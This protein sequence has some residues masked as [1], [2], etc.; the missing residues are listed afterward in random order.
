MK[1][2][3]SYY[4]TFPNDFSMDR[5]GINTGTQLWLTLKGVSVEGL[6]HVFY[7]LPILYEWIL[8]RRLFHFS[9][10]LSTFLEGWQMQGQSRTERLLT[11]RAQRLL[12]ALPSSHWSFDEASHFSIALLGFWFLPIL[13][14]TSNGK[15][16]K[17][18]QKT[19]DWQWTGRKNFHS[20]LANS[21]LP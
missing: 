1:I 2:D 11:H 21:N 7:F 12:S 18:K 19:G 17:N 4:W 16:T 20:S 6:E 5:E 10:L 13:S 8:S 15:K 14:N 3:C 9:M